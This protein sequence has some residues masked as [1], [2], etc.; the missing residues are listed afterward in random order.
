MTKGA[1]GKEW[2]SRITLR[3]EITFD[4]EKRPANA[5]VDA[6]HHAAHDACF[7]ANTIKSEILVS[8]KAHG[9]V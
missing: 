9:I 5:D 2:M 1:D 6:L 7:I 8:G 4:G 3:P